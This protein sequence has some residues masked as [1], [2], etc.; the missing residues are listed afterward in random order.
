MGMRQPV[1]RRYLSDAQYTADAAQMAAAGWHVVSIRREPSGAIVATY[2]HSSAQVASPAFRPRPP[3]YRSTPGLLAIIGGA[4]VMISLV[5][6]A[7]LGYT[8]LE[9][10]LLAMP[11]QPFLD[12]AQATNQAFTSSLDSAATANAALATQTPQPTRVT[13][14]LLGAPLSDFDAAFGLEQSQ[15]MWRTTLQGHT[16]QIIVAVSHVGDSADASARVVIID[17]IGADT[18]HAWTSAQ[19]AALVASFLRSDAVHIHDIPGWN[20][21]GPDHIFTS[22]QLANSLAASVFQDANNQTLAP[23]TFDWQCSTSR[24]VCEVAVGTN[25]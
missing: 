12:S 8:A 24:Q 20:T 1:T 4:V 18:A 14:P 15:G 2:S 3:W 23:G 25:S 7:L 9:S 5:I 13:G 19:D 6:G 11:P 16:A 10:N 21:L 22:A 17:I